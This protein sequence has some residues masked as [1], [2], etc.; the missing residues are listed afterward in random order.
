MLSLSRPA[1]AASQAF[2]SRFLFGASIAGRRILHNLSASG[3]PLSWMRALFGNIGSVT[4]ISWYDDC[5]N[6]YMSPSIAVNSSQVKLII[7]AI[8][9]WCAMRCEPVIFA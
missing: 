2:V 7:L 1:W 8:G 6:F 4:V 9:L 5:S 3:K